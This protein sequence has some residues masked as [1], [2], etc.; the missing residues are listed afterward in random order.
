MLCGRVYHVTLEFRICGWVQR[1]SFDHF[2]NALRLV[3]IFQ[4][5]DV[6]SPFTVSSLNIGNRRLSASWS[7]KKFSQLFSRNLYL[8]TRAS[9][10]EKRLKP[11]TL[12]Q[13]CAMWSKSLK[14]SV[15]VAI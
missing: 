2:L 8:S 13:V 4:P 1:Q 10:C 6:D 5:A 7:C 11:S 3:F 14:T 15:T 9:S 12:A